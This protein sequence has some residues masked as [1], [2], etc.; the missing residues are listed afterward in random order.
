MK[1]NVLTYDEKINIKLDAF[2]AIEK[3]IPDNE[4][5]SYMF[6]FGADN[7]DGTSESYVSSQGKVERTSAL[8]Y[9]GMCEVQRTHDTIIMAMLNFIR[10]NLNEADRK[11]IS[12][13]ALGK[14]DIINLEYKSTNI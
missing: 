12:D 1:R 8:V 7:G 3:V 5:I 9:G 2:R 10:F 13:F 6:F 14:K 11:A 4:E